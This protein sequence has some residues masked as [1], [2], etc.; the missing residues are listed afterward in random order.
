MHNQFPV[1]HGVALVCTAVKRSSNI[2]NGIRK[3]FIYTL[4]FEGTVLTNHILF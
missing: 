2:S 4:V 1:T 3:T